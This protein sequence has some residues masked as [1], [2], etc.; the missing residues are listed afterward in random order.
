MIKKINHIRGFG[1][2]NSY[3]RSGNIQDFDKVNIIYGWNYSGKTTIS[4]VFQCFEEKEVKEHYPSAEFELEDY[5]GNK[6]NQQ[7]LDINGGEVK[8]FNSDF[9]RDNIHL[10]G[11]SFNPILLLG[12][13]AKKT[14]GDIKKKDEN[15]GRLKKIE[16]NLN[17]VYTTIESQILSGLTNRASSI[18][19]TLQIVQAFT[20]THLKP[21]FDEVKDNHR[22]Y[23][24]TDKELPVLL[25]LATASENDKLPKKEDYSTKLPIADLIKGAEK[26]LKEIPEFSSTVQYFIENPDIANWVE[27]GLPLH[28]E[29]EKCEFC[30]NELDSEHIQTIAAHFSEDLKNHKKRLADF[31]VLINES[32]IMNPVLQKSDFY[33]E[34]WTEF[35]QCNSSLK[36]EV[37]SYNKQ[38]DNIIKLVEAKNE[39]PFQAI[40]D[41]SLIENN[42]ERVAA[43]ISAYNKVVKKNREKTDKFETNKADA[44]ATLKK[45]YAAKFVDEIELDKKELKIELYKKREKHFQE[46]QTT[47]AKEIKTL[48]AKVS[49]A[50]KGSEKLNE[51]INKFLGRDE[52]KVVVEKEGEKERFRLK[53]KEAKAVNLS[54]GEKTAIAFSFFLT[55]LLECKD[56]EK[57]IV[58]IDD[59]ISSLDSNHIFQ[60]NAVLKDFFYRK[61]NPSDVHPKILN[62]K[63]LFLSTHNFDFFSLLR[64][65]PVPKGFN[66]FYYFVKRVNSNQSVIDRLPKSLQNYGSEYHYLFQLI[67]SFN[68]QD[69]KDIDSAMILPNALRRFVE[70]YTYSRIPSIKSESVDIRTEQ[71]WGAHEAKR[72]LKVCHYFSHGASIDRMSK[73]N[74]FI[75]DIENAVKDLIDLLSSNDSLHYNELI[76]AVNR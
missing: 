62:C 70:L 34:F 55:K 75:C 24:K 73:H 32:K 69:E 68:S 28:K 37:K 13:D 18:K 27:K 38:L 21:I 44:Q 25:K 5:D 12:E 48:E 22:S 20:R 11:E 49:K 35:V 54:E 16:N 56:L 50:H 3:R 36:E 8:V 1:V 45:H 71:L 42:D 17:K 76:K 7:N 26:L 10:E 14:E 63:Q 31:I 53:R 9:I 19:E 51:F 65:L 29:K 74:D 64:E 61:E 15:L 6:G 41:F 39:K 52:I 46:A 58:Y 30:G 66:R 43:K 40:T 47:L 2:F 33:K 23:I 67:H 60:V 72:I 59:P 4:R 57:V